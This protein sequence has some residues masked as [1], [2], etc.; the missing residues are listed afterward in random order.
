MLFFTA[1]CEIRACGSCSYDYPLFISDSLD[2][3][4][5]RLERKFRFPYDQVRLN[6][7]KIDF[8]MKFTN[9]P[10]EVIRARA[11]IWDCIQSPSVYLFYLLML[12]ILVLVVF[13][14]VNGGI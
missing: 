12:V 4:Y 7:H 3:Y 2:I 5:L 6:K 13:M 10:L 14:R 9:D 1:I 8:S 11:R